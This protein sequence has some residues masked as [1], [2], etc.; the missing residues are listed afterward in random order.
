MAIKFP[1]ERTPIVLAKEYYRTRG[2]ST[3]TIDQCGL[4]AKSRENCLLAIR[5]TRRT[6]YDA[7]VVT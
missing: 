1:K 3:E 7:G 4:V 5:S 2:I 6:N